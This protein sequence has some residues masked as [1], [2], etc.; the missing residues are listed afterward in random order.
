MDRDEGLCPLPLSVL[1]PHLAWTSVG[2]VHAT[3]VCL[4]MCISPVVPRRARFLAIFY[5]HR[6]LGSSCLLRRGV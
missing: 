5:P 3:S 1:G 2:P 4:R 6:L